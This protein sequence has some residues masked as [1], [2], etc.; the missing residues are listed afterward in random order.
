MYVLD[1]HKFS[2]TSSFINLEKGWLLMR[3]GSKYVKGLP[4]HPLF[5]G[6][7]EVANFYRGNDSSRSF[8]Y[9]C[10]NRPVRVL[11]MRLLQMLVPLIM[12]ERTVQLN[13]P[14]YEFFKKLCATQGGCSL[15]RQYELLVELGGTDIHSPVK[16]LREYIENIKIQSPFGKD[17]LVSPIEP[18]GVRVGI[19]DFD[20]EVFVVLSNIF[21]NIDG[22]ISPA[23]ATPAHNQTRE[24]MMLEE[25]VLFNP[26]D[27]LDVVLAKDIV[28]I[29][30]EKQFLE[31]IIRAKL[32]VF[33]PSAPQVYIGGN[34]PTPILSWGDT[35]SLWRERDIVDAKLRL[36]KRKQQRF[37]S[38]CKLGSKLRESLDCRDDLSVIM[39]YTYKDLD[40]R[41]GM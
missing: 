25:V 20:Y 41:C 33:V 37:R 27:C 14:T 9:Y 3:A 19:T 29:E 4:N 36:S 31:S 21:T 5:L 24:N 2:M 28:G 8:E 30:V 11:D 39:A 38:F 7:E 32:P 22:F 6:S 35:E 23:L 12:R 15:Q 13:K 40:H 18:M 17:H 34:N 10:T 26:R 16:R 1:F